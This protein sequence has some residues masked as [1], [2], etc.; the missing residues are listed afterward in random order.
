MESLRTWWTRQRTRRKS[1][2]SDCPDK[3]VE[4]TISVL[5]PN[6]AVMVEEILPDVYDV[7]IR[8]DDG[9]R[10][11][12]FLLDGDVPTLIDAGFAETTDAMF[13]GIDEVGTEPERLVITHGDPDH[14][15][16]F[17]ATVERY[18]V[19]SWVPEQTD[20]SDI[21]TP[22]N[23]FSDGDTIGPFEAVHAPGH[24][25][26]N[27][28]LVD[29]DAGVLVAGDALFGADLRGLPEGYLIPPAAL[30][31]EDVNQAEESLEKLLEYDFESLLVFHGSSVTEEAYDRLDAF[32]NFPG[33]P[34]WATYR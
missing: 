20:T 21:R 11:R 30:Y 1:L 15:E 19:E 6:H 29:E 31:S 23:R 25:P 24:E 7:T 4:G 14:I 9:R 26:D 27:Y 18:D 12:V 22:D 8:E 28:A 10:N 5:A 3:E 16:G 13:A 34:D 33:K 2:A 32:V 17:N